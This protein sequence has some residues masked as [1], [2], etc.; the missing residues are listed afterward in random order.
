[1]EFKDK[2]V[3]KTGSAHGIGRAVKQAFLD[4]S[5]IVCGIDRNPGEFFQGDVA[6]Q[7]VLEQFARRVLE[8]HSQIDFLINNA[9]PATLGIDQADYQSFEAALRV[10]LVA[11]FYLS[12]LFRSS[13]NPRGAIVN[14]SS[15]RDRLSQ[16]QTE[17]YTA[18]KGGL[19]ALT[20][21][22][23]ISLAPDIRVNAIAP[24]WINTAEESLSRPDMRQQPVGRV[25]LPEDVAELILFLCSQ[26][27]A[28][29]TGQTIVLDG[30]MSKQMIYHGAEGWSKA[31]D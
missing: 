25:G 16:P 9:P 15:T 10:G 21:S 19:R 20:H 3:V 5:A 29:L 17:S 22:L 8:R 14:L 2:V 12:K 13:F 31:D 30:G 6:E 27:S 28:Y 26:K 1:M 11:P 4:Q 23:A 24:G 18:A 7:T